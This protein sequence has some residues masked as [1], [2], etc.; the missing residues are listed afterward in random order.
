MIAAGLVEGLAQRGWSLALAES[1][2]GG[3]IASAVTEVPG[4]S[5]VFGL[6]VVSYSYQAKEQI[7]GIP[8][9]LLLAHGAVSEPCVMAML[10]GVNKLS[11]ATLCAAVTGIA[12]PGG[13]TAD[14]KVGTVWTALSHGPSRWVTVHEFDGDRVAVRAQTV[15]VVI[16]GLVQ[17][18]KG[19]TPW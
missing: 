14:K 6:G 16:H 2:T 15:E 8:S 17:I 13:A 5:S 4:S 10:D 7:L 3:L 18:M 9:P 19:A 1:C 12:G 11:Q